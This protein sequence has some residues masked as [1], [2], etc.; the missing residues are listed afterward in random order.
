MQANPDLNTYLLPSMLSPMTYLNPRTPGFAEQADR[1]AFLSGLD[2]P[3]LVDAAYGP[4]ATSQSGVLPMR[5]LD[6]SLNHD[7]VSY[8]D[9]AR[10]R[11]SRYLG[12]DL[13]HPDRRAEPAGRRGARRRGTAGQGAGDR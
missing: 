7:V 6:A 4:L 1:L 13:L 9:A 10:R 5:M 11:S 2:F 8:D 12:E 3:A